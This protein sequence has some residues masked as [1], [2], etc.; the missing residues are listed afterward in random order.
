[1]RN[2]SESGD[3]LAFLSPES[4]PETQKADNGASPHLRRSSRKRKSIADVDSAMPKGSSS[5]KKRNTTGSGTKTS[6]SMPRVPRSPAEKP[7]EKQAQN[8]QSNQA[9]NFEALLTGMEGRLGTK[10]DSTNNKV[11]RALTLVAQTNTAIEDLELRM[12]ATEAAIEKRLAQLE[13][14]IQDRMD[15]RVKSMV[16]DQLRDAGF[17]PELTAAALPSLQ[18]T[19]KSPG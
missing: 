18:T 10:I 1:M 16:L 6:P 11:E 4:E 9:L 2:D 12:E 5:K 13:K 8:E 17:D 7:A 14:K 3:D 19:R 15:N